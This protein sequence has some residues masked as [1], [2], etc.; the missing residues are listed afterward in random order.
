MC[1]THQLENIAL[2]LPRPARVKQ[3][4]FVVLVGQQFQMAQ[5]A[6]GLGPGQRRHQVVDN[7]R[8]GPSLGLGAL[9]RV[10]DNKGI[11]V[12][13]RPKQC[14]R[15]ALFGQAHAL[16]WQPFQ[17]AML[18]HMYQRIGGKAVPQPKMKGQ[19]TMGRNQVR[20]VIN[21]AGVD[22]ITARRLNADEG[23][24]KTQPGNHHAAAAKHRVGFRL[25]PTL[26]HGLLV[27]YRQASKRCQ[28]LVKRHALA[29][30]PLV[31][32]VQVIA[33]AAQQG[34]DQCGARLGQRRERVAL[35]LQGTQHIQCCR[36]GVQAHPIADAA[37]AGRVIGQHQRNSL[38]PI[39]QAAQLTPTACQLGDK[40]HA[41][42]VRAVANHIAL[43]A[44][45]APGQ[46]LETDR[47]ADDAAIE[48]WQGNMHGQV[49]GTQPLFAGFPT[50]LVVLGAD[51]L[52]NR[53]IAAKRPQVRRFRAGLGKACG[54]EDD[55][56]ADLIQPVLDLSQATGLLEAGDRD[57][58]W[59]Q[60]GQLQPLTE[61]I[62]EC[63]VG[64][65]QV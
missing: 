39:G 41:L 22:L 51:G 43:A 60:A 46:I 63:R 14:I 61:G 24:P 33:D 2:Q 13:H 10:I 64:R 48:L 53:N 38:L 37:I 40:I 31:E 4:G 21:R 17:I 58:Q 19:V 5:R 50:R 8:L 34:L 15:P 62:D 42:Q 25:A 47:A 32:T 57:R 9:A 1:F 45:A 23:Q 3:L 27:G 59:V 11:D 16:A 26:A 65:L 12:G 35:L 55:L 44:L 36:R 18:A 30:G 28:V 20:V 6:V 7:H 52:D 54:I 29:T 56:G 49:A